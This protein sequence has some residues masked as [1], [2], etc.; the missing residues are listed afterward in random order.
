MAKAIYKN[1]STATNGVGDFGYTN[2]K[3]TGVNREKNPTNPEKYAYVAELI[4]EAD[5]K[6]ITDAKAQAEAL[7]TEFKDANGF[8][9]VLTFGF[10][11]KC[12]GIAPHRIKDPE[13]KID[14]E[15]EEVMYVDTGKWVIRAYTNVSNFKTGLPTV[16]K[17][18]DNKGADITKAYQ[19]V[20]FSI[21][22]G[23][24]GAI[25]FSMG[26]N[27]VGGEPKI[28]LYLNGVQLAKLVKYEGTELTTAEFE[29]EDIDMGDAMAGLSD[30]A[31]EPTAEET[32]RV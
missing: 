10:G 2:I 11:S 27:D 21:G 4:V 25:M 30:T 24:R 26:A 1:V 14:P 16:V 7:W 18:F 17:V 29:G 12:V 9:G 28:T 23:S 15:T 32:P 8:K 22:T 3:G 20:D 6:I 13:G 31:T 5:S 19:S